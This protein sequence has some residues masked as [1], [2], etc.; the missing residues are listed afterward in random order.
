MVRESDSIINAKLKRVIPEL[1][2]SNYGDYPLTGT[3]WLDPAEKSPK[4]E[5]GFV[6]NTSGHDGLHQPLLPHYVY[7]AGRCGRGYYH[8]LTRAAYVNLAARTANEAPSGCCACNK[9]AREHADAYDDAR[10]IMYNR[11]VAS[12]PNDVQAAKD[13]VTDAQN[14]AQAMYMGD[15]AIGAVV[16]VTTLASRV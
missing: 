9:E 16:G 5:P 12:I 7:G 2:A 10:R 11:S 6:T 3:R 1:A 8:L 15:Q 13:A 14:T 4:G